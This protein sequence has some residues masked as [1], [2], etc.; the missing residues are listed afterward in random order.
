MLRFGRTKLSKEKLLGG[1]KA[2]KI[3]N[4]MVDKIVISKLI[5][6]KKYSKYS[7]GYLDEVIRPL[8]LIFLKMSG[9]LKTFKVNDGI[10]DH[11]L[12]PFPINDKKLLEKYKIIWAKIEDLKILN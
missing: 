6:T 3:W 10:R 4:I 12:M 2:I 7:I 9:R 8:V 11:E 5:A 1:K